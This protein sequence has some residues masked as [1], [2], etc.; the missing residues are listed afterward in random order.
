[1]DAKYSAMAV[2]NT[3]IEKANSANIHDLSPMKLQKLI[4]FAHGW[5]LANFDSPL[6]MDDIQAWS[7]GPVISSIYHEFKDIGNDRITRLAQTVTFEDEKLHFVE[8]KIDSDDEKAWAIINGVWDL[9]GK[10]SPIQLSNMTHLPN[11]PWAQIKEENGGSLPRNLV[12]P[13]NLIKSCFKKELERV[14]NG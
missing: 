13:N 8:P 5:Y 3:F 7:Y 4:Y 2:A 12:I 6:I 9:Y 1:M 11:T 14:Q 10:F